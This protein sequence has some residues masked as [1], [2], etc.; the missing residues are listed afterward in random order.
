[1]G[2]GGCDCYSNM[3]QDGGSSSSFTPSISVPELKG[4][5]NS[6]FPKGLGAEKNDAFDPLHMHHTPIFTICLG[7]PTF[8]TLC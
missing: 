6:L 3:H 7:S 1:M 2:A 5:L 8:A 4:E